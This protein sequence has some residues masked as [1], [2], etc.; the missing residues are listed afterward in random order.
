ME[1]I[2]ARISG[3]GRALP[4]RVLT[5]ADLEQIVDTS[6]AWIVERT[7]IRERRILEEGRCA[8]D[9]G[10]EAGLQACQGAGI[11]PGD[12]DVILV[13]TVTPDVPTPATAAF[14]Q[15]KLEAGPCAAFDI[16][17]ACAGFVYGLQIGSAL[18]CS[19]HYKR[20][21]VVGVE[22]LSRVV[23]WKDRTTCV[24]F[25]DGAGAV[26]MTATGDADAGAI[27]DIDLGCD[28][29][30]AAH[31]EIPAGGSREPASHETLEARRHAVKMNGR[32][33]FTQA[34][35]TMSASGIR[36]LERN[37]VTA[38][39]IT[40]VFAHQANMRILEGVSQRVGIPMDRFF[41]NIQRYGN[42]SSASIPISMSEALEQGRLNK[43]DLLLLTSLGAGVAWGSALV[44]W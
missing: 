23:D 6:D 9:L 27:L 18:I 10:A 20:V 12:L 22:V 5:N 33:I 19:G 31:L 42:T 24:L 28:G 35:K 43:G 37:E 13:A 8:S 25:G 21:L 38:A 17:A 2:R 4:G 39:E 41:N 44:R 30:H 32:Q 26:V 3:V 34:V 36:I 11:A 14:V 29:K 40:T 7:G 1:T 16:S 15:Q